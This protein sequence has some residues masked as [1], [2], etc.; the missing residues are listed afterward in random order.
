VVDPRR[1]GDVAQPFQIV[2]VVAA[3]DLDLRC[4]SALVPTV[5]GGEQRFET[6]WRL[7]VTSG[8][9]EAR[10]RRVRQDVDFR[11]EFASASRP[12]PF[13]ARPTR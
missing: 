7:G 4:L 12:A 3:E 9:V 1:F 2:R 6:A 13:C 11:T 5:Q 10:E 8:R